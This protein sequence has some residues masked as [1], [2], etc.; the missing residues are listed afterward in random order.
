M[1]A[2]TVLHCFNNLSDANFKF[3]ELPPTSCSRCTHADAMTTWYKTSSYAVYSWE[4]QRRFQVSQRRF[5]WYPGYLQWFVG[6]HPAP[7]LRLV[8]RKSD[9]VNTS[10]NRA[11]RCA[12]ASWSFHWIKSHELVGPSTFTIATG[13]SVSR[14]LHVASP[15]ESVHLRCTDGVEATS[16]RNRKGFINAY[17]SYNGAHE[18]FETAYAPYDTS[19]IRGERILEEF[20]PFSKFS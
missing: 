3:L 10:L 14:C 7:W 4:R 8:R 5:R 12:Y 1:L 16:W 6:L 15:T 17:D 13:S 20:A 19:H 2:V 11:S 9:I 18:Q